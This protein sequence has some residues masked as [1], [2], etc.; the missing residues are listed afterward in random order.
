MKILN[1]NSFKLPFLEKEEFSKLI[2][3]GV[4]YDKKIQSYNLQKIQNVE[5]ILKA[6]EEILGTEK[7]S[8]L[9]TCA[10]CEETF[11]CKDCKYEQVCDTKHLP[12]QCVCPQ[13]LTFTSK[14]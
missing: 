13:C 1:K 6:L 4:G 2:R 5:K 12:F 7:I 8:F 3:L 11:S 14:S 9:Q 10:S